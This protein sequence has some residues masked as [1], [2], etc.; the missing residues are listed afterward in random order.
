MR[1]MQNQ[2]V[3]CWRMQKTLAV[4]FCLVLLTFCFAVYRP[5]T[6]ELRSLKQTTIQ[7]EQQLKANQISAAAPKRDRRAQRKAACR[8]RSDQEAV[9]AAGAAGPD[10][11]A[12]AVRAAVVAEEIR[13][14]AKPADR[15][16]SVLRICRCR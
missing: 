11:R 1:T 14:Q 12:V 3:W 10:Q 6:A 9:E 13:E 5:A 16:R 7:R 4:M 8:A 2:I 15:G